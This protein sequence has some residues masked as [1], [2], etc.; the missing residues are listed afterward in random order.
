MAERSKTNQSSLLHHYHYVVL[1][2]KEIELRLKFK[3]EFSQQEFKDYLYYSPDLKHNIASL[4]QIP[5][6][7]IEI[8]A[9]CRVFVTTSHESLVA[10]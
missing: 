10:Q 1:T 9:V 4:S 6:I 8:P 7:D 5:L 2:L 3:L